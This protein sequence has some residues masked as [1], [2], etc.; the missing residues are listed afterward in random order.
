MSDATA[1]LQVQGLN[2]GYGRSQVLF[3][4]DLAA[5]LKG[6]IA[7]LGRNGAGKTT[8]LKTL[9]GEIKPMSGSI[10]FGGVEAQGQSTEQRVRNG[11]GY[12]PQEEAIFSSLTVRDNLLLGAIQQ[13]GKAGLDEVLELFPK[14]G[15][16][17]GQ[18]AGTLSGG[19]RKMLA[20]SRALLG[21]PRLLLLDEPTEGVW[22][23]VIE[24]LKQRLLQLS[25]SLS[26]IL[27]EQHIELALDVADFAY[28]VDRGQIVLQGTAPAIRE[29]P[30]LL[31]YL[32]P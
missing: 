9:V 31:R 10:R 30:N 24:E 22:V 12:V 28:V 11:I 17:L 20:I 14:L 15:Q 32:S 21:Q 16:R 29:D 3:N 6:A 13:R 2:A 26:I 23:G 25:S 7:I 4:I 18:V 27:V 8:L 19:E 1:I 5:Q